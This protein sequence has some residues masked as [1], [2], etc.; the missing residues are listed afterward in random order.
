MSAPELHGFAYACEQ[1]YK[2]KMVE[3]NTG[4]SKTTLRLS[5]FEVSQKSVIRGVLKGA[6]GDAIIIECPLNQVKKNVLVNVWNIISITDIEDKLGLNSAYIDE[7]QT[8]PKA[9]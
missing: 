5:D 4:E 7:E 8:W 1:L 9:K 3:V 2:D 6:I